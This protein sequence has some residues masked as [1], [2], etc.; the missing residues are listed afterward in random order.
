MLEKKG[1]LPT[2]KAISCYVL[3]LVLK[4]TLT[5]YKG[6][7]YLCSLIRPEKGRLLWTKGMCI[8]V[9]RFVREKDAD[10]GQRECVSM[11]PDFSE[12]LCFLSMVGK[13]LLVNRSYVN[14]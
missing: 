7:V 8:Y 14:L 1:R 3:G 10:F 12:K 9:P 13:K 2:H 5:F 4:R 6:N 11:F